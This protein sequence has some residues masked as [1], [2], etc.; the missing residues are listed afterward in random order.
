M[1]LR[2]GGGEKIPSLVASR[3]AWCF[4]E[5]LLLSSG[6]S[7]RETNGKETSSGGAGFARRPATRVGCKETEFSLG[8]PRKG[9]PYTEVVLREE[10]KYVDA[11]VFE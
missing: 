5:T 9:K 11:Q 6:D 4:A 10:C 3:R 8:K 2:E 1:S 7:P